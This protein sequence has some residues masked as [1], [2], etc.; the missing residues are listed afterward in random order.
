[1]RTE[2][3]KVARASVSVTLGG[4]EYSIRQLPLVESREWKKQIASLLAEGFRTTKITADDPEK[5]NEALK[6][7]MIDAPDAMVD[8][9]FSY[10]KDLDREEIES[11]ATETEIAVAWEK[12]REVAFPLAQTLMQTMT[13]MLP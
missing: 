13:K 1:M 11:I 10:A 7:F 4:R 3:E 6:V 8:L 5:F 12:V 9:F 2:E